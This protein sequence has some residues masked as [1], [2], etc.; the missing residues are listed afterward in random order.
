MLLL[1]IVASL[2]SGLV[3]F[4]RD[5][6]GGTRMVRA[7]TWRVGLSFALFLLLLAAFRFGVIAG[8]VPSGTP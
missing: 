8:Y 3:L 7:L 1:A 5:R 6:S 2:F 4:Y